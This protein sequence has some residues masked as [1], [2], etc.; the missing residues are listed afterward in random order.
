MKFTKAAVD[1]F[2]IEAGRS[3]HIEFDDMAYPGRRQE[4]APHFHC[5]IQD[6]FQA[7]P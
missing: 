2:K 1:R 3:E 6:R 4:A 5:S 7:P